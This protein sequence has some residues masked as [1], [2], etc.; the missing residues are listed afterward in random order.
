MH[1]IRGMKSGGVS[2]RPN[3]IRATRYQLEPDSAT[4]NSVY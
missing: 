1:K 3:G 4:G 2:L